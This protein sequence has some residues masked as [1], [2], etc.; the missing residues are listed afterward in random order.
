MRRAVPWLSSWPSRRTAGPRPR[1]IPLAAL[2]ADLRTARG[3][4]LLVETVAGGWGEGATAAP[5]RDWQASRLGPNPPETLATIR[6]DTFEAVLAA[7]GT[8]PSL[9]TDADGTAQREAV[10]RWHLG[11]VLPLARLLEAELS[12]KLEATVRLAFDAYPLDLAGRA[13]AFQKLVAGGVSVTEALATAGLLADD[14]A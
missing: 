4:A 11:T 6:R 1:T 10:R 8:P 2:K 5:R 12:D 7:T 3:R 14:A 9:F 13:Q